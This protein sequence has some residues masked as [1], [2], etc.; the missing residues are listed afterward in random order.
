MLHG[1]WKRIQ[2]WLQGRPCSV[3]RAPAPSSP[4]NSQAEESSARRVERI[5]L[6]DGVARTLFDDFASHRHSARGREEIG[7]DLLGYRQGNE[8]IAMAALPAGM[9]RDAGVAHVLFNRDVQEL[10]SHILRQKDKR[11]GVVGVVHTHPGNMRFPSDGDLQGDRV[12]VGQL[13]GGE[14]AF[15]IGTADAH[16]GKDGAFSGNQQCFGDLCFSWYALARGDLQYRPLP[17]QVAIGPDLAKPF[18]AVWDLLETHAKSLNRLYRQMA[19]VNVQLVEVESEPAVS[20]T[21][22]V[23]E[24]RQQLCLL[25][26]GTEARYYWE[27]EGELIA[28]DP[29]EPQLDRAVH[30]ILAELA[31]EPTNASCDSATLVES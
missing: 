9:E 6:A 8:L 20:V 5:V 13:R 10:L 27:R 3:E 17:V 30:L 26:T 19:R 14:G 29:N 23:G 11:L 7:W 21:I 12:W 31:K 28:V 4:A 16:S 2:A 22:G 24:P 1:W 25:L 15:A 18:F